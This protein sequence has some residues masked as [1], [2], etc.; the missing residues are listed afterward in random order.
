[1]IPELPLDVISIIMGNLKWTDSVAL[2]HCALT[3]RDWHSLAQDYLPYSLEL[4]SASQFDDLS[5]LMVRS[6]RRSHAGFVKFLRIIAHL[7]P[8][9]FGHSFKRIQ[10]LNLQDIDW[11]TNPLLH[12]G[13]FTSMAQFNLVTHLGLYACR[14]CGLQDLR[15]ILCAF[16][17][18]E[19]LTLDY[20]SWIPATRHPSSPGTI[21]SNMSACSAR[22]LILSQGYDRSMDCFSQADFLML[23]SKLLLSVEAVELWITSTM[24]LSGILILLRSFPCVTK[25]S[26][27][28]LFQKPEH[29]QQMVL[30]PTSAPEPPIHRIQ[31]AQLRLESDDTNFFATSVE[32]FIDAFAPG[33]LTRLAIF[34]SGLATS[35]GCHLDML[36]RTFGNSLE[37]LTVIGSGIFEVAQLS[38]APCTSLTS[39]S[40]DVWSDHTWH[41]LWKSVAEILFHITSAQ[42]QELWI[43]LDSGSRMEYLS[44]PDVA[45]RF[46]DELD[47]LNVS[48]ID[49]VIDREKFSQLELVEIQ[50]GPF[51]ETGESTNHKV[52]AHVRRVFSAWD[53]WTSNAITLMMRNIKR[54]PRRMIL[55][56][57]GVFLLSP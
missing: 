24:D 29:L 7:I 35:L 16:P 25:L 9:V 4:T 52:E 48:G 55:F 37:S 31:L 57:G 21:L 27:V 38:L 17:Q 3:C 18:L 44:D 13:F 54:N 22:T 5:H 28:E 56:G 40:L 8:H 32:C 12:P 10:T 43:R 36:M 30:P 49:H 47:M 2:F 34:H 14:F 23:I 33:G 50:L 1:M 45:A 19:T 11:Q 53:I 46:F 51:H 42:L 41:T 6:G 20:I 26:V 39:L 15:R